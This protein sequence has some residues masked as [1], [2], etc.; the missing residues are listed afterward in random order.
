MYECKLV[1]KKGEVKEL[2]WREGNS[3]E[4]VK[5]GL[6]MFQWPAGNWHIELA[7]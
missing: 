5:E 2:L 7:Q 6:E 1:G 3:T 4:E